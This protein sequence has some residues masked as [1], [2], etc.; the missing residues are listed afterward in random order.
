[1]D[2]DKLIDESKT[3]EKTLSCDNTSEYNYLRYYNL[4]Y[5]GVEDLLYDI[6]KYIF[7]TN[8]LFNN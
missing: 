2:K 8:V 3:H 6:Y 1:M 4:N 5:C 7:L